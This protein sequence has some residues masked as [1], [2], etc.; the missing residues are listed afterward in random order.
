MKNFKTRTSTFHVDTHGIIHK[1]VTEGIHVMPED[2]DED[3]ATV[4][5]LSQNKKAYVLVNASV[6]HTMT[7]EAI[8]RLKNSSLI[9]RHA[10]AL[11]SESLG[12]R[13]FVNTMNIIKEGPPFSLFSNEKEAI[14]WLLS[15]KAKENKKRAV[16]PAAKTRLKNPSR[17]QTCKIHID[18]H[19]ILTKEILNGVHVDL[20]TAKK[21]EKEAEALAGGKKMLTL[22]DRRASYT[23]TAGAIKYFKQNAGAKYRIATALISKKPWYNNAVSSQSK[24]PLLRTFTDKAS[25][26][27]W[28]L[29][30]KKGK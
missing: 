11:V 14:K 10:T 16:S 4:L 30:V 23:V 21:A 26:V 5:Q 24:A 22:I 20:K 8:E 6:F 2:I 19:G 25:A 12:V 27:K 3:D 13:I 17:S 1:K 15:E 7:P 18:K 9:T 29:S 28:L